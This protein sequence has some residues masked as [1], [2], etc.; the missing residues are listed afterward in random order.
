MVARDLALQ[1][2]AFATAYC[3]RS[4]EDRASGAKTD[5]PGL[6]KAFSYVRS[7]D[8]SVVWKLD[9]LGC[10]MSHL[11]ET[12]GRLP[13]IRGAREFERDLIRQRKRAGPKAAAACGRHGGRRPVV[14]EEKLQRA[15]ELMAEGLTTREATAR[16]KVGKATQSPST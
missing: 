6:A 5:R 8:V 3:D 14:T 4:F 15:R 9:R 16:I 12:V 7:R 2:N 11:I 1:R 13:C 10:S